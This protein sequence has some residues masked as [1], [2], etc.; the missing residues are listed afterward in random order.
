[1]L[2]KKANLRSVLVAFQN[3][4]STCSWEAVGYFETAVVLLHRH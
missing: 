3:R 1:M 2:Q 4:L